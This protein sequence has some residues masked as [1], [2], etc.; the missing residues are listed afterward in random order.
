MVDERELL[1]R[2]SLT[3]ERT[4]EFYR[5]VDDTAV[6][7]NSTW[8]ARDALVH[9][10]FWHESFA[11]NVGDL[12][13]GVKPTPLKGTY[14]ELGRRASKEAEGCTIEEL[15][16]RLMSAQRIIEEAIV[17]PLVISI[18]YKVGSRP[19]TPAEHLGIV[20]DHVGGH[21]AKVESAYA[22]AGSQATHKGAE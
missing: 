20:N 10:V 3:V 7:V 9:V 17:S 19:Y 11:R 21:L 2:L 13:R 5:G 14:A 18:P 15:L 1:G 12:A 4:V 6:L 16:S 8:T 22:T